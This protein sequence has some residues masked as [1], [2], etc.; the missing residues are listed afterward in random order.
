[1]MAKIP[2]LKMVSGSADIPKPRKVPELIRVPYKQ[3][4]VGPICC[5]GIFS[6]PTHYVG[7]RT[8]LCEGEECHWCEQEVNSKWYGLIAIWD[9]NATVPVWAQLTP[10]AAE[11]LRL[12]IATLQ[13]P[14][15]GTVVR[16]GR[17]RPVY[18]A[19]ITVTVDE[20]SKMNGRLAKPM[21]P[22]ETLE[23]VFGSP[24]SS[25]KIQLKAI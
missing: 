4:L 23:K 12:Q 21:V 14:L 25:P 6:M 10:D 8:V 20:H 2:R 22:D 5:D 1:M 15:Y 19:P 17:E 24:K 7:D 16:L 11:S 3:A 9:R 18:N 13:I